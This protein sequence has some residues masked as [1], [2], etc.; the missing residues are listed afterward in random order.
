M[1][2][3]KL[4]LPQMKEQLSREQMKKITGGVSLITDRDDCQYSSDTTWFCCMDGNAYYMSEYQD[5][6]IAFEYCQYLGGRTIVSS[7]SPDMLCE[8]VY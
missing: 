3:L 2:K 7:Y 4:K 5:C 1:K 6:N 8:A